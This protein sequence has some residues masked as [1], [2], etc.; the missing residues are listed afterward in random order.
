MVSALW[1]TILRKRTT[2]GWDGWFKYMTRPSWMSGSCLENTI[3]LSRERQ[4]TAA[5]NEQRCVGLIIRVLLQKTYSEHIYFF[6]WQP[7]CR[8]IYCDLFTNMIWIYKYLYCLCLSP[9]IIDTTLCDKVCQWLATGPMVSS[10]N[11]TDRH[12]ITEI[13]L[14]VALNTITPEPRHDL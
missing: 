12:D 9:G 4:I 7:T 1:A 11:K 2:A 10:I 8:L 6:L 13:L 3:I 5:D 14:K